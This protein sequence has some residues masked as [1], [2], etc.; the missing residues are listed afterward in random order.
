M[1][2]GKW[3]GLFLTKNFLSESELCCGQL[4]GSKS[5]FDGSIIVVNEDEEG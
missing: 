4:A 1:I 3:T 5:S 2:S